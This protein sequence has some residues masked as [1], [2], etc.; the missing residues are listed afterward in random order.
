MYNYLFSMPPALHAYDLAYTFYDG[1]DPS[2]EGKLAKAFQG[3]LLNFVRTGDPN[4][5]G[6]VEFEKY[7][8]DAWTMDVGRGGFKRT[9]GPGAN[10]RCRW[11][12]EKFY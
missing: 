9:E 11:W 3:H 12:Q 10:E 2:T 6:M 1:T 5:C 7:G 4:G 8:K